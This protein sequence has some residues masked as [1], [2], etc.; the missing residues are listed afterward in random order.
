MAS[1]K[2]LINDI[3]G[4]IEIGHRIFDRYLVEECA[5]RGGE[6]IVYVVKDLESKLR[7][8]LKIV[9]LNP[10]DKGARDRIFR[11]I[12]IWQRFQETTGH[13]LSVHSAKEQDFEGTRV[14][15]ILTRY[16]PLGSLSDFINSQKGME[17]IPAAVFFDIAEGIFDGFFAV[18]NA[19]D[20]G[21]VTDVEELYYH[22]DIKPANVI[23]FKE[24]QT[25]TP[26]VID[27]G[28]A[29]SALDDVD[30]ISI[31]YAAPELITQDVLKLSLASELY[32]LGV[33][34]YE[35]LFARCPVD[36]AGDQI[37]KVDPETL[38]RYQTAITDNVIDFSKP[39]FDLPIE[40]HEKFLELIKRL[41]N[42]L[43]EE[44][45]LIT[46]KS[47]GHTLAE[48][49]LEASKHRMQLHK[50][51]YVGKAKLLWN[52]ETHKHFGEKEYF[53][54]IKGSSFTPNSSEEIKKFLDEKGVYCYSM[55]LVFGPYDHIVRFWSSRSK[56]EVEAIARSYGGNN[57]AVAIMCSG[58]T[59]H[60]KHS[61]KIEKRRAAKDT[62]VYLT[63]AIRKALND[64]DH[65]ALIRSG[66]AL[67]KYV[68]Q[69][70]TIRVF[71]FIE[72]TPGDADRSP[73]VFDALF[74]KLK[75]LPK[76]QLPSAMLYEVD[77]SDGEANTKIVIEYQVKQY[78]R[79]FEVL[80]EV[81]NYCSESSH[82]FNFKTFLE[83]TS[84]PAKFCDDGEFVA[85]IVL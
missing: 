83:V 63:D 64:D 56:A 65:Q 31:P 68:E 11:Q 17:P 18:V 66:I 26:R 29:V 4:K 22:G 12:Q 30:G 62:T 71:T 6:G 25:F 80:N 53:L 61:S 13:V 33:T 16:S 8:A 54:L 50:T 27:F 51:S 78:K 19:I 72:M 81:I 75:G 37:D 39:F 32:S 85:D 76:R 77:A 58:K 14:I 49:K 82:K 2:E 38:T 46:P 69:E 45:E 34:F 15:V 44:R 5:G 35:L 41:L 36:F 52:P 57:A 21:S 84:K 42:P 59:T 1:L 24:G 23:M 79:I 9:P 7:H 40:L 60:T 70:N 20:N 73:M 48:L 67:E 43:S 74:S 28:I 47:V 55:H 10:K 3:S